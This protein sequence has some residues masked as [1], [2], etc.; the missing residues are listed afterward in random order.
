[1]LNNKKGET[2][3]KYTNALCEKDFTII[4]KLN[5]F[6][7]QETFME[8]VNRLI[9]NSNAKTAERLKALYPIR[10][11]EFAKHS[12]CKEIDRDFSDCIF[13]LVYKRFDNTVPRKNYIIYGEAIINKGEERNLFYYTHINL[14]K[15]NAFFQETRFDRY[16]IC[17]INEACTKVRTSVS[18]PQRLIER[19]YYIKEFKEGTV[20]L[21]QLADKYFEE[22]GTKLLNANISLTMEIICE[23][24][25][26]YFTSIIY[27]NGRNIGRTWNFQIIRLLPQHIDEKTIET[28]LL[29][30][31]GFTPE[32]IEYH[33]NRY[34][35]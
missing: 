11:K 31:I 6:T 9:S 10:L 7:D 17:Q 30:Y 20:D 34:K 33:L 1:M 4:R 18:L 2:T 22:T 15:N 27:E 21:N 12:Y 19:Y 23:T 26:R 16:D 24:Y 29:Y 32:Q 5:Q 25:H 13:P 8:S 14:S 3:M 35:K 28:L